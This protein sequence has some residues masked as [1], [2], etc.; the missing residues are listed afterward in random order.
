M[1]RQVFFLSLLLAGS[2]LCLPRPA[3]AQRGGGLEAAMGDHRPDMPTVA[4]EYNQRLKW[5]VFGQVLTLDGKPV[6]GAKVLV[7][8]G[9]GGQGRRTLDTNL[10][11]EFRT[12]YTLDTKL[13][14]TLT[15]EAVASKAG[16]L[17]AREME[18]FAVDQGTTGIFL[19]LR[20]ETADPDALPLATLVANLAPRLREAGSGGGVP[21][22]VRKDY[23]RGI[24]QFLDKHNPVKA[25]QPLTKAV[26]REP[27]C[28]ECRTLL[29]LAQLQAGSWVGAT[30]QL[31]AA[32]KIGTPEKPGTAKPE[33][34]LILG[35][36]ETWRRE[37]DRAVGFLRRGLEVQPKDPLVLQELG[38]ALILRQEWG[39]AAESLGEAISLRALPEARLLRARAL[40]ETGDRE[41]AEEELN[42]CL[43][44]GKPKDLPER[45]RLVYTQLRE[46]L[47]LMSYGEV[48]SVVKQ[49]VEELIQILPELKGLEPAQNQ[50]GL[51]QLVERVGQGVEAYFKNFPN[52]VSLEEIHAEILSRDGK[53]KES[54]DEKANY[55]LLAVPAKW[56]LGLDE[57]RTAMG[58][59]GTAAPAPKSNAMRTAGFACAPLVF[60]PAYQA[61]SSFRYLG[62]QV[63]DGRKTHVLAFA[64]EPEKAI[65]LSRFTVGRISQAVLM[66]GIAWVDPNDYRILRIRR[67][68]LRPPP[69]SR[70]ERLTTEIQFSEV[71]FK[72]VASA[73]WLPREVVVHVQWK[74][75]VFR[76]RHR[77]SDFRFFNV[78][79]EEKRKALGIPT[80][81]EG[82][83]Q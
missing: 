33:P 45:N 35:V 53:A 1:N 78:E 67:D 2:V 46:R 69:K 39:A 52:T 15:V 10:Q 13:Y 4:M 81:V 65:P 79:A 5:T 40:L 55:L 49:S 8:V 72:E 63:I 14:K 21:N 44:G 6:R 32:I 57:Y 58:V 62:E 75:K 60:H 41:E 16:Y 11:G 70:L 48:K 27:G 82:G 73:L 36:M 19:V 47:E 24:E 34:F 54:S 71:H 22:S 31:A 7:D 56:G 37:T 20:E 51:A 50:D 25:V 29:S 12:E 64:Q 43:G 68:L 3:A 18:R 42:A 80:A 83:P 76:N 61:G 23:L 59:A 74:G 17:G 30:R 26:E 77:Y 28:V 66:Q 9:G 38:R